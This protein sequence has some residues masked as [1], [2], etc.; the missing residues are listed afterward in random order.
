[1]TSTLARIIIISLLF[2]LFIPNLASA[3][4]KTFIKEYTFQAGD[5]DSK[6]SSRT[7]ALW[8]VKRLLLE[9]LGTYLESETTVENFKLTKDQ[10]ITLTAGIVQTELVEEKWDGRVY[11]LKAKIVADSENVIR[12]ISNLRQDRQK[13]K[14]LEETRKRSEALLKQ[15][16][17]LRQELAKAKGKKRQN[18]IAA[19]DK[20]IKELNANE[21]F[22]KGLAFGISK[23]NINAINAFTK[24]IELNPKYAEAYLMRGMAYSVLGKYRHAIEDSNKAIKLNPEYATAYALRCS[25]YIELG[26]FNQAIKDCDKAIELNPIYHWAYFYRGDAYSKMGYLKP[27]KEGD[28]IRQAIIDYDK[29]IELNPTLAIAYL[30]RGIANGVL[31]NKPQSYEDFKSAARLGEEIAQD[32]LKRKGI[33]W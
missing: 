18:A 17:R 12:S 16:E 30:N 22:E 31:G 24:A 4:T 33:A 10:I 29:A 5:E 6:N 13:T 1:M 25:S 23:N 26:N 11:W 8:E 7:I 28:E 19:Y 9:E 14:E 20:T 3:E 2:L 21:W 15:N 27:E 32:L